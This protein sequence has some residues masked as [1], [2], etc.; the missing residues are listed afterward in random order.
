[1]STIDIQLIPGGDDWGRL[2][3]ASLAADEGGFATLWV[4]DHLAG[5]SMSSETMHEAFSWL[6]ALAEA[7]TRIELGA[8]VVNAHNRT[9]ATTLVGAATI[10]R[11][12][13]RTFHLGLGA[14]TSPNSPFA[15]EQHAT[16]TPIATPMSARHARVV[17]VLD[18]V[19]RMWA[20]D[21]GP[22]FATFPSHE[23]R[24]HLL[25]GVN[26]VELARIAGAR[27]DGINVRWPSEGAS[28]QLAAAREVAGE[29][30]FELT[31]YV[32][33]E[34]GIL[35]ADHPRRLELSAAGIT[36]VIVTHMGV[37]APEILAGPVQ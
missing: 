6:G 34:D 23:H 11:L 5:Y 15:R 24:P 10:A 17:E 14:G 35:E 12:S 3:E 13:G 36:R 28:A 22:E 29:R 33:F 16:S 20:T 31:A 1:M 9:P 26:S 37:P 25:I 27:A 19:D 7:T 2:R 30:P 18:L 21:P 8:L 4:C 32:M